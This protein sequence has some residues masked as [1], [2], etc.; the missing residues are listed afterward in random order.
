MMGNR[1][2]KIREFANCCENANRSFALKANRQ[3]T[4]KLP[5]ATG[6]T[7]A[8]ALRQLDTTL[9][10]V[11]VNIENTMLP[12][13]QALDKILTDMSDYDMTRPHEGL[14]IITNILT[15]MA[16]GHL[17]EAAPG[18]LRKLTGRSLEE[19]GAAAGKG[20]ASLKSQIS[21]A[22]AA[23]AENGTLAGKASAGGAGEGTLAGE[24]SAG[25]VEDGTLSGKASSGGPENGAVND[26]GQQQGLGNSQNQGPGH[27]GGGMGNVERRTGGSWSSGHTSWTNPPPG[28]RIPDYVRNTPRPVYVQ[29]QPVSCALACVKMVSE[30]ITRKSLP[31]SWL[32]NISHGDK[33]RWFRNKS[34]YLKGRSTMADNLKRLLDL[35]QVPNSG[36]VDATVDDIAAATSQGYPAIVGV[37]RGGS[38]HAIIVDAVV[39]NGGN[40]FLVVRDPLNLAHMTVR[41]RMF[42]QLAGFSNHAIIPEA[43][44]NRSFMEKA[45]FTHP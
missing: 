24:A 18:A 42:L 34:G 33:L 4:V 15:D 16:L 37:K 1:M 29:E 17:A 44:F 41:D 45:I 9:E 13:M 40:R 27:S 31:E 11:A 43:V 23:A 28:V 39:N 26:P 32:R 14:K 38:G 12:P 2:V 7:P 6:G 21:K 30:T 19:A 3:R 22:D 5:G 36:V 20:T 35:V 8:P 25:G 10:N